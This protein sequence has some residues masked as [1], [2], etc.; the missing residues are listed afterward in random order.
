[1]RVSPKESPPIYDAENRLRRRRGV[2]AQFDAFLKQV[3]PDVVVTYG[4]D[5]TG[6]PLLTLSQKNGAKTVV[7]LHN[8]AYYDAQ[9]F[10]KANLTIVPSQYASEIYR[11]RLRISTVAIP[12]LIDWKTVESKQSPPDEHKYLLFVNPSRSK[13]IYL[14][15]RIIKDLWK[16]RPEIPILV[17]EGSSNANELRKFSSILSGVKSVS[18]KPNTPRPQDYYRKA[19]ITLVPSFCDETFGRVAAESL[20]ANVPVVASN[21]GALPETLGDAAILLD[22]PQKY[23][24]LT[25]LVPSSSVAQPWIKAILNLWDNAELYAKVQERGRERARRWDHL[26][27][28]DNYEQVLKELIN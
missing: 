17:V 5:W 8:L 9:Y 1:M 14:F 12:P 15:V 24:S 7:F 23:S 16:I 22:I 4:G 13:G 11:K 19:K 21:R 28:L 3:K 25:N 10:T 18:F 6:Q 27:I 26:R 20:I 2:S